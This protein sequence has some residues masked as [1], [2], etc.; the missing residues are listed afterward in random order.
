LSEI[1]ALENFN[2][3]FLEKFSMRD[4]MRDGRLKFVTVV[5]VVTVV[6]RLHTMCA[7]QSGIFDVGM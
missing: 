2:L 5:T 7:R 1:I 4:L 6:Q 3:K